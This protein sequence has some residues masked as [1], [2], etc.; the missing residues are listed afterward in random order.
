METFDLA[1]LSTAARDSGEEYLE[2]IRRDSLS[3]GIYRLAAGQEDTQTPH[4]EDE[5][6]YVASGR[7]RMRVGSEIAPVGAGTVIFVAA[8]QEHQFVDI[9]EDLD[10]L[11]FFAPAEGSTAS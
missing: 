6:Y 10:I 11:V 4:S 5:L 1:D 7:A 3:A 2:F 8:H 9:T